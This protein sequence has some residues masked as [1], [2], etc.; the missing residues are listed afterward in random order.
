MDN[1]VAGLGSANNKSIPARTPDIRVPSNRNLSKA[2]ESPRQRSC[3]GRGQ[4]KFSLL[5]HD[6]YRFSRNRLGSERCSRI[7]PARITSNSI[8]R[9]SGTI[10]STSAQINDS[11]PMPLRI[12]IPSSDLSNPHNWPSQ[13]ILAGSEWRSFSSTPSRVRHIDTAEVQDPLISA[14]LQYLGHS[15]HCTSAPDRGGALSFD[16]SPLPVLPY[17]RSNSCQKIP[18]IYFSETQ[19]GYTNQF[20]PITMHI[21]LATSSS[22]QLSSRCSSLSSDSFLMRITLAGSPAA[23]E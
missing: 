21:A 14:E 6:G 13:I 23:T 3:I 11:K 20:P 18:H 19:L 17:Q 10:S 4:N 15:L 22:A 9:S 1:S 2:L 5:A 8:S 7:S 12:Q 16:R